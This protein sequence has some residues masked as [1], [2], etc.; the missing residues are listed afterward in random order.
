[1]TNLMACTVDRTCHVRVRSAVKIAVLYG[2]A[3]DRTWH[4]EKKHKKARYRL[5]L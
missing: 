5:G 3:G 1:M 2:P 4:Y